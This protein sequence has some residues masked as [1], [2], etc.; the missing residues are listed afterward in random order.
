MNNRPD[1]VN[2]GKSSSHPLK[3]GRFYT[4]TVTDLLPNGKINIKISELGSRYYS[5]MP[6]KIGRA[7]V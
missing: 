2:R 3:P 7:H 6:L 4:G 1:I 5:I